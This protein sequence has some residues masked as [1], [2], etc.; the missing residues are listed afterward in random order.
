MTD[1]TAGCEE[2]NLR[3]TPY[4]TWE[5]KARENIDKWGLQDEETL[6]LAMQEE[7]GELAQAHLEAR[8]EGGDHERVEEE[9]HDLAALCLQLYWRYWTDG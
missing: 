6:L 2:V 1:Q 7:I 5:N 9:L 4:W 8:A 3:R